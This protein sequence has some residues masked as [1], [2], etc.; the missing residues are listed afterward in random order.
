M[1]LAD[2][3]GKGSRVHGSQVQKFGFKGSRVQG[4][5]FTGSVVR[6]RGSVQTFGSDVR[7]FLNPRTPEPMNPNP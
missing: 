4:F 5:W 6:F 7:G 2:G 3:N 1:L